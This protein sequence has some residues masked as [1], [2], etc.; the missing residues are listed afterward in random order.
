MT[1]MK[2]IFYKILFFSTIAVMIIFLVQTVT[3]VVKL[4]PLH[5]AV[6]EAEKPKPTLATYVDGSFQEN[7]EQYLR[8][9]FG[10]REWLI[11]YYNQYL[12]SCFHE[13]NNATI[14]RGKDNWLFEELY[15]RNHYESLMYDYTNDT[16]EMKKIFEKEA[17]RLKKVQE[18]LKEYDIHL[19]V[20]IAPSKDD[21]Y[22]E[23][24]P[25]NFSYN[26]PVG[27]RAYDYYTK[28]FDELGV[29]YVDFV[30]VF[31]NLK[32][33]VDYP[34]FPQTGTHWT[35]IASV[36][37]FDSILHYMAALG[38]QNLVDLEIG[39]KYQAKTR[40]FDNDLETILNLARPVK[41]PTNWYVDVKAIK[42]SSAVK[43]N[44][45]GVGDSYFWHFIYNIP[46][47]DIFQK[48]TYWYYNY[49]IY[50]DPENTSPL[51][52]DIEQELMKPDYIMLI[53][54]PT[55]LYKFSCYYLPRALLHLCYDKTVI[56]SLALDFSETIKLY[57]PTW[58]KTALEK[59]KE[60]HQRVEDVLYED[61]LYMFRTEPE[62][63]FKELE[64][65]KMPTSRNKDLKA[66]RN[67][68]IFAPSNE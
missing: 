10:F 35:S 38:N 37:A 28:R 65:S 57:K 44:L 20:V 67:K 19:F 58:Y 51:D 68:C 6:L 2:D 41:T 29:D 3:G 15:V 59:A 26:R 22:P 60:T 64:G 17:L 40:D 47:L 5:G 66:I 13:T 27:V 7:T 63:Y 42:D 12:W 8:D 55:T 30:P 45:V 52:V 36:F 54:N 33:T 21:I 34:L 43:P 25:P 62:Q 18:L 31:K 32:N 23:Y 50:G 49:I 9:H 61:A 14:V 56:D 46:L 16:S 39:E 24:L 53:F 4:E 1:A 48:S 11:R